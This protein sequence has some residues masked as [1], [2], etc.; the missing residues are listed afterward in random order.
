MKPKITV[1]VTDDELDQLRREAARRRLSLS[2]YAKVRLTPAPEQLDGDLP[3]FGVGGGDSK[4]G[5]LEQG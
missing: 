4:H 2:R 1:Y 5:G 3:A